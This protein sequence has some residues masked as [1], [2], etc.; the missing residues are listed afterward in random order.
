MT[1]DLQIVPPTSSYL[2]T[3]LLEWVMGLRS[4]VILENMDSL[5]GANTDGVIER[6]STPAGLFSLAHDFRN[7]L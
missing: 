4:S 6:K 5:N 2:F 1:H 3:M 7:V